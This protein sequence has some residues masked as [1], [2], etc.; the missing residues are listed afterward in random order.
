[1]DPVLGSS[2][3]PGSTLNIPQEKFPAARGINLDTKVNNYQPCNN[4]SISKNTNLNTNDKN[5]QPCDNSSVS[6]STTL[7]TQGN[8]N[9]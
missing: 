8:I 9:I 4:S 6:K 1:M 2:K 5:H 7:D 3:D